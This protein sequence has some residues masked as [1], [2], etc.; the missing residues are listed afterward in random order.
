MTSTLVWRR[1]WESYFMFVCTLI[2][3]HYTS[4]LLPVKTHQKHMTG[5]KKKRE[6]NRNTK[7][8]LVRVDSQREKKKMQWRDI[9]K[10][11][12][13]NETTKSKSKTQVVFYTFLSLSNN[14]AHR[15]TL[16][17]YIWV[18]KLYCFPHRGKKERKRCSFHES[19][20]CLDCPQKR[21]AS[22]KIARRKDLQ[23]QR[24][25]TPS[26]TGKELRV[27]NT[28]LK[29][30]WT[31]IKLVFGIFVWLCVHMNCANVSVT[32]SAVVCGVQSYSETVLSCVASSC[33]Q[34]L[35]MTGS[36]WASVLKTQSSSGRRSSSEKIRYRYLSKREISH[37]I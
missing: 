1:F 34:L 31:C 11:L 35:R 26:F 21:S 24:K 10:S 15:S 4:I 22:R 12:L 5:G 23:S 25:T 16:L 17:P 14:V 3:I 27:H 28:L 19:H 6:G 36:G 29:R 32:V 13:I 20:V 9:R 8:P 30:L 18:C 37:L 2:N 33:R 7:K